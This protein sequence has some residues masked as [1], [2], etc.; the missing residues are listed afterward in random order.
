MNWHCL[1]MVLSIEAEQEEFSPGK[2]L[3]L[4]PL[5]QQCI[6]DPYSWILKIYHC[7]W[8]IAKLLNLIN[9]LNVFHNG[10]IIQ[11]PILIN[12]FELII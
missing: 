12:N 1:Q 11:C 3:Y 4:M 2:I 8:K 9:P 7:D 10:N 6:M 5:K